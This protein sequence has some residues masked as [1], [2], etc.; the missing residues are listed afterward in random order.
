[1]NKNNKIYQ[2][3]IRK[4]AVTVPSSYNNN[5]GPLWL[6]L[7]SIP[8]AIVVGPPLLAFILIQEYRGKSIYP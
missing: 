3:P 6:R 1:M 4:P 2:R 8:Y 7:I 5:D